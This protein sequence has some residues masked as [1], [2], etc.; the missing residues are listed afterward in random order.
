MPYSLGKYKGPIIANVRAGNVKSWKGDF[1]FAE[2]Q[3]RRGS[4]DGR[5]RTVLLQS[6]ATHTKTRP[7]RFEQD[8]TVAQGYEMQ[9][10]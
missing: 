4:V 6:R 2:P 9:E 1:F 7:G 8:E 3:T 10:L 5:V